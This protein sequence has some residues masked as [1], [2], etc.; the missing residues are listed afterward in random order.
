MY[1]NEMEY[2]ATQ[3]F[4]VFESAIKNSTGLLD[5]MKIFKVFKVME[6]SPFNFDTYNK[7]Y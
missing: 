3:N 4:N 6:A 2:R 5:Q 7:F 1:K